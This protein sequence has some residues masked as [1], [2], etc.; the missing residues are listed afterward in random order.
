MDGLLTT[1]ISTP[2]L[3]YVLLFLGL[4]IAI[5]GAHVPGTGIIE[6][7]ALV[8]I[9]MSVYVLTLLPT[10]WWAFLLI[11][12]GAAC[13]LMLPYISQRYAPLS[14]VGLGLQT[15]GGLFLFTD[16]GVSLPVLIIT[17][18]IAWL[19][20]RFVL[21]P[22]LRSQR[23]KPTFEDDAEIIG[24]VGQVV[25]ALEP[26]GTVKVKGETWSARADQDLAVG[27]EIV[28]RAREG[29]Q[30]IVEKAKRDETRDTH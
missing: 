17:M 5:T 18:L 22:V 24:A 23:E 10:N 1:L 3:L 26:T 12:G 15:V 29:L 9:G 25:T 21:M 8:L 6:I 2:S 14:D 28:V 13:F 11:I 7:T 27:T 4:W 30:L 20:N 19:Y 16:R